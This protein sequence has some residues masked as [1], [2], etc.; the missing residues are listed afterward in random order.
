[1]SDMFKPGDWVVCIENSS[2]HESEKDNEVYGVL[3]RTYK[4]IK[5]VPP[6]LKLEGLECLALIA[7]RFK[8]YKAK[9][10]PT[11]QV[12]CTTYKTM[13]VSEHDGMRWETEELCRAHIAEHEEKINRNKKLSEIRNVLFETNIKDISAS[14]VIYDHF[15][16]IKKIMES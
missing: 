4:V 3:G 6:S 1:M 12:P 7:S 10:I 11:V 13:Y 14:I 2:L 15:E 16:K 9:I 5:H 8:L